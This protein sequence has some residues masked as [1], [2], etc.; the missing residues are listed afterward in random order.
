VNS[1]IYLEW[2]AGQPPHE[3]VPPGHGRPWPA[4]LGIV[5][6]L[7]AATAAWREVEPQLTFRPAPAIVISTVPAG[8]E[9]DRTSEP[10]H[11]GGAAA[12]RAGI[13]P[14][15]NYRY[16][17]DGR[18]YFGSA[19]RRAGPPASSAQAGRFVAALAPG[20]P[21]TAWYNPWLREDA[22]LQRAPDRAWLAILALVAA[23]GGV[24]L[25]LSSPA[26]ATAPRFDEARSPL[27]KSA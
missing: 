23:L 14:E 2:A 1:P 12:S 21:V 17:V 11:S 22:V 19:W 26:G 5:L 13:V 25:L 24:L 9:G 7:I 8:S 15:V 18:E 4:L 20:D 6:L 3:T 27:A 10:R 16:R